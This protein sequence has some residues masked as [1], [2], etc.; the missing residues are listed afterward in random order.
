MDPSHAGSRLHVGYAFSGPPPPQPDDQGSDEVFPQM[1]K[2][3]GTPPF[4]WG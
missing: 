2:V 4:F 1:S 3:H